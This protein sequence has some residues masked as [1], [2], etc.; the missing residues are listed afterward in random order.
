MDNLSKTDRLILFIHG[1]WIL[2]VIGYI[3]IQC[4]FV[5]V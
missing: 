3:W 5:L 1:A 2:F 4:A